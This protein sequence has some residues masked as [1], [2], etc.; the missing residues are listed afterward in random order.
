MT[1][2]IKTLKKIFIENEEKAPKSLEFNLS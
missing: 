1:F 2:N